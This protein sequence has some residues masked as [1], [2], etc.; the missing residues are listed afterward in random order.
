LSIRVHTAKDGHLT[1]EITNKEVLKLIEQLTSQLYLSILEES[2][3]LVLAT[4]TYEDETKVGLYP[5]ILTIVI[6]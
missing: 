1:L 3:S 4:T 5:S 2:N 6:N